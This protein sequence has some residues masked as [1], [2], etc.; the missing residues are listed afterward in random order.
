MKT[1]SVVCR[2]T[3]GALLAT[4]GGCN[5]AM[6]GALLGSGLG[7]AAGAGIDHRD[8]G[9]GALIGSSIGAVAGYVFGNEIDKDAQP[10]EHAS[11][12][13]IVRP[14]AAS[15]RL[16]AYGDAPDPNLCYESKPHARPCLAAETDEPEPPPDWRPGY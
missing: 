8:R 10:P 2:L 9:R 16:S 6:S 12:R 1:G 13:P 4:A 5:H 15:H 3:L 7:A 11:A 14:R